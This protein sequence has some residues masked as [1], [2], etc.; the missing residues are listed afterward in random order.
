MY[1][2]TS[3]GF[4]SISSSLQFYWLISFFCLFFNVSWIFLRVLPSLQ[5]RWWTSFSGLLVY[6]LLDT[7]QLHWLI[8]LF[9]YFSTSLSW[10]SFNVLQLYNSIGWSLSFVYFSTS[11]GFPLIYCSSAISLVD[12]FCLFSFNVSWISFNLL[13]L[14]NSIGWSFSFGLFFNQRLL[15][16]LLFQPSLQFH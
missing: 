2:S 16:F 10:M 3:A 14:R 8:S 6:V 7:R 1:F 13:Q 4:S 11:V 15:D 12:L 5:F 9:D